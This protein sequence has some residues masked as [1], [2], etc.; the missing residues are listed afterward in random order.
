MCN[1]SKV[2]LA[3]PTHLHASFT[4]ALVLT[5]HTRCFFVPAHTST[6]KHCAQNTLATIE[7]WCNAVL[8]CGFQ[9]FLKHSALTTEY[10]DLIF[11]FYTSAS[12]YQIS[13]LWMYN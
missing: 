9:G 12:K 3:L 2:F 10:K 1:E 6:F 5:Q 11:P 8:K 4:A 7:D 13:S